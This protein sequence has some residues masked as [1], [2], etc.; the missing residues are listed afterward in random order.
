MKVK[1]PIELD[2]T[3]TGKATISGSRVKA[4]IISADFA[5][6]TT[7]SF[8]DVTDY[9]ADSTGIEDST[10]AIVAALDAAG[11][12][13][14]AESPQVVYFPNGDYKMISP[15][16]AYVT[17]YRKAAGAWGSSLVTDASTD[18]VVD[19]NFHLQSTAPESSDGV[20]GDLWFDATKG[21]FYKKAAGAWGA[22]EKIMDGSGTGW[23]AGYTS[24]AAYPTHFA[25]PDNGDGSDGDFAVMFR[26]VHSITNGC[27]VMFDPAKHNHVTLM[28]ESRGGA[29]IKHQ[30]WGDED[31]DAYTY[32][33]TTLLTSRIPPSMD[34]RGL[35]VSTGQ[36]ASARGG[37]FYFSA[38]LSANYTG[39]N[40]K[41]LKL[42]GGTIASGRNEHYSQF[43]W[44]HG[45]DVTNKAIV[46]T[47]GGSL[48]RIVEL[49]T[50]E[51]CDFVGWRGEVIYKGGIDTAADIRILDCTINGC[52]A[53]AVSVSGTTLIDGCTI[54]AV[55]NGVE[56]FCLN[57]QSTTITDTTIDCA[58]DGW[59]GEHAVAY[60]GGPSASL[61]IQN[62]TLEGGTTSALYLAEGAQNV[63]VEDSILAD[64]QG[65]TDACL[66]LVYYMNQYAWFVPDET[67]VNFDNVTF[68]RTTFKTSKRNTKWGILSWNKGPAAGETPEIFARNWLIEDCS[69]VEENGYTLQAFS[70]DRMRTQSR[71]D[72]T[73]T[74]S[75]FSATE[76]WYL[77]SNK[78]DSI[79]AYQWGTGN[80]PG[81]TTKHYFSGT[82]AKTIL[83]GSPQYSIL[84][85]GDAGIT[86]TLDWNA[87]Q[88]HDG[89]T[90]TFRYAPTNSSYFAGT[91][92]FLASE[93][94]ND[95]SA[96]VTIAKDESATFVYSATTDKFSLVT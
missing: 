67:D 74:G 10:A 60:L 93:A 66:V 21:L 88:L 30:C 46:Y 8:F 33:G 7:N 37:L 32:S 6:F 40:F 80:T 90:A 53:S 78:T 55:Y 47:F 4:S 73:V 43:D 57:T 26:L 51:E 25:V 64:I 12:V 82:G 95:L 77:E 49:S 13:A 50:I 42:D 75:D 68:R 20:D 44:A 81:W 41:W 83:A 9:G 5:D 94:W 36:P 29:T 63:L 34:T 31:P 85:V 39:I 48:G 65:D 84:T 22:A 96:D 69:V 24:T 92:T 11:A 27:C 38:G 1:F 72:V 56:N 16:R 19:T 2:F 79:A 70:R 15:G 18:Q 14:S 91:V 71:H 89:Y 58:G 28:G 62:S 86:V 35:A 59:Q 3:I 61:T 45:W 23:I 52:N 17:V 54:E 87:D 76:P